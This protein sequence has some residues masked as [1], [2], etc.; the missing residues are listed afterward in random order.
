[1]N[2]RRYLALSGTGLA[3][4]AGCTSSDTE[5]TSEE[6]S[7]ED[8]EETTEPTDEPSPDESTDGSSEQPTDESAD[9]S[10]E[11]SSSYQVRISYDGE[12]SGSIGGDGSSR[13]VDGSGTETFDVDG[14]PFIVSANGQKQDDS[15]GELSV[16]ILQDGE[17]IARETT[18]AEY[19]LAQVTSEDG[20]NE[21]GGN[22][23]ETE[24][25]STYEVRIEYSGE[26]RGNVAAGGS[27]RSIEG[28]GSETVGVDGSPDVISA[29]AQKSD[30]SSQELTI[31]ILENGDV[32]EETSTT[33]EYGVAQVTHSNF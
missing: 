11:Q 4:L 6:T 25:G 22:S 17:V 8:P 32:V 5:P 7:T 19:G 26:W 1:M 13:T 16:E 28:T 18:S 24:S 9:D 14:D 3:L 12:W 31:Q 29:N 10:T 2:R 30:D 27:S 15:S 21:E 20:I 33:A 23:G